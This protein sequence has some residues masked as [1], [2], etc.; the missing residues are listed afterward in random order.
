MSDTTRP[1][2]ESREPYEPLNRATGRRTFLKWSGMAATAL[3]AA[4]DDDRNRT[5]TEVLPAPPPDTLPDPGR[6]LVNLGSGDV[7]ILN[8][9]LAL[10]QLEAAFYIM[11]VNNFP[12]DF[13]EE[14]R[15]VFV[16]L[17]NHEVAHREFLKAALG[18]DAIRALTPNFSMVN[19]N[20]RESVLQTAMAF[21]DLGVTA[22]N[23]AGPLL[24]NPDFL[25]A[26]GKIASVEARHASAIRD[27]LQPNTR[28][29]AG[30]D[31][32]NPK[33]ALAPAR[34]P[35]E[36]LAIADPFIMEKFATAGLPSANIV[37]AEQW[38]I[39]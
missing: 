27:L 15:R 23:G 4:C 19:F 10:E 30:D 3:V 11:V 25:V 34:S 12:P 29:F 16:D 2:G 20:S 13:T 9:A 37:P 14:D 6:N 38:I 39:L 24:T 7:G 21:E 32:V 36:V 22:Y 1:H 35:G 28:F 26:A 18:D 8:Y 5:I 17:R 33:L 31:F